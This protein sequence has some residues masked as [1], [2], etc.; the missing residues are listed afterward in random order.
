MKVNLHAII[1]T[2]QDAVLVT[3]PEIIEMTTMVQLCNSAFLTC[4]LECMLVP[5]TIYNRKLYL[6]LRKRDLLANHSLNYNTI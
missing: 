1:V 3:K 6:V 5:K 2:V 4:V